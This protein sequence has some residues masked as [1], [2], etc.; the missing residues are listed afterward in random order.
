M[1]SLVVVLAVVAFVLLVAS[2]RFG[3]PTPPLDYSTQLAS[4]RRAAPYEILAPAGL[5]SGWEATSV[6]YREQ[7]DG[8]VTWH[9]GFNSPGGYAGL[10]QSDGSTEALLAEHVRGATGAEPTRIAGVTWQRR[11]G[12]Q[13]EPRGLVHVSNGVTTLVAGDA[14]WAQLRHLAAALRAG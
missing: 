12:G 8:S 5:A 6:R 14:T 11:S 3:D 4:A 7:P 1:R 10:E 2:E 13:P 9:L